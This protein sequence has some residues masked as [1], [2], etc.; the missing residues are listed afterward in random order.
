[1]NNEMPRISCSVYNGSA[2]QQSLTPL[3]RISDVLEEP[4][5][6]VWLDIVAPKPEDFVLIQT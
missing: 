2:G 1:M 5:A 4:S 6:F 3:D